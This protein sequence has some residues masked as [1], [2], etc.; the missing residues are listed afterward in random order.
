[1]SQPSF[2]LGIKRNQLFNWWS[3]HSWWIKLLSEWFWT[4]NSLN[5]TEDSLHHK[6]TSLLVLRMCASPHWRPPAVTLRCIV[7]SQNIDLAS[8]SNSLLLSSST[9]YM[10]F[11]PRSFCLHSWR[12]KFRAFQP[13]CYTMTRKLVNKCFV[14]QLLSHGLLE[15]SLLRRNNINPWQALYFLSLSFPTR[16]RMLWKP[17]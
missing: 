4:E 15:P 2:V 11:L 1:M 9:T 14:L 3:I 10:T 7:E 12:G 5:W 17:F 8:S 6:G 13:Y 16:R